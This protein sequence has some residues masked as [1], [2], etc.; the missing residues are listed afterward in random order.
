MKFF[1]IVNKINLLTFDVDKNDL[2][3]FAGDAGYSWGF[4]SEEDYINQEKSLDSFEIK[5]ENYTIYFS[6]DVS[7]FD[8]WINNMEEGNYI[9]V[10]VSFDSVDFPESKLTEL[11]NDI[12]EA[13]FEAENLENNWYINNL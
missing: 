4:D 10:C 8:Y 13:I 9:Q 3:L 12:E 2:R 6:Y 7:G 5:K 1:E 11:K